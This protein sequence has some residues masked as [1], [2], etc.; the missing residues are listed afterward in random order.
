MGVGEGGNGVGEGGNGGGGGIKFSVSE[1][2]FTQFW[3][4]T[5]NILKNNF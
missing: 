1:M 5:G 4:V 2:P 3:D